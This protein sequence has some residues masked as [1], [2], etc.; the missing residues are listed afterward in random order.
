VSQSKEHSC[1]SQNLGETKPRRCRC[2]K[3]LSLAEA[4]KQV[5]RGFAQWL[6]LSRTFTTVKEICIV[7]ANEKFKKSCQNC[8][9]TGE[10]EKSYPHD[11]LGTDIVLVTTG[12]LND[13]GIPVYRS[14]KAKQTP[15]VATIEKS[16]IEKAYLEGNKEETER[17]E[18]YG[19]M[20]LEARIEMGIKPE[21]ADDPRTGTGRHCDYGRSPFVRIADERTSIGGVGKR[22]GEG[23]AAMDENNL[24]DKD[25]L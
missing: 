25:R 18:I 6:I 17:I 19:L 5:E 13:D 23:F 20:I 15:R 1:F 10:V 11:I 9:G 14:V 3:R 22:I 12:A 2:R 7:C 8:H 21:P 24:N 16:H 4:T